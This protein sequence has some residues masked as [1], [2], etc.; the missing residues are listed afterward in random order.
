MNNESNN[1][2]PE[3]TEPQAE[4]TEELGEASEVA[5][6]QDHIDRL[7]AERNQLQEQVLRTMAEFQNFRKRTQAESILVRQFAT[8][9]LVTALLPVLDNFD[10]SLTHAESGA[11]VDA[12]TDGMRAVSRQLRSVLETQ[13]VTRIPAL[14][15]AFDPS[16]HEAI[17]TEISPDVDED[18]IIAEAEAGYKMGDKVIRP[19]RV[20]VARK[21]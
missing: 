13:N 9:S 21:S 17:A 10:R 14:G 3:T 19:A 18:S 6:L 20:M 16:L 2:E 1:Q 12:V 15:T 5:I 11:T 8:E 7:T 4:L